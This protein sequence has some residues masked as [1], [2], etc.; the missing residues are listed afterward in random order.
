MSVANNAILLANAV[1]GST[2]LALD[3][4]GKMYC[5][6]AVPTGEHSR[7]L[8]IN[9]SHVSSLDA[10]SSCKWLQAARSEKRRCNIL[11]GKHWFMS[12]GGWL[13]CISGSMAMACSSTPFANLR[14]SDALERHF[15]FVRAILATKG[16][17]SMPMLQSPAASPSMMVVPEPAKGSSTVRSEERRVGQE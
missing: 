2:I 9:A 7:R 5:H 8:A 16:C 11:G 15:S 14:R 3:L 4:F 17:A 13:N 1:N 6:W 10:V 12:F